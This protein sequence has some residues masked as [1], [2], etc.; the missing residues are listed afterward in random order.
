MG[1]YVQIQIFHSA[2]VH[3]HDV[4]HL[5]GKEANERIMAANF[6]KNLKIPVDS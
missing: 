5:Q 6:L 3:L 2:S 1:T 4:D